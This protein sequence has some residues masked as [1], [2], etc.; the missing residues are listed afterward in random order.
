MEG[1]WAKSIEHLVLVRF[2]PRQTFATR[3]SPI[4]NFD[5]RFPRVLSAD[6]TE[7]R[8]STSILYTS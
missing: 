4:P 1:G 6:W 7:C 5:F 8:M 2:A 3:L